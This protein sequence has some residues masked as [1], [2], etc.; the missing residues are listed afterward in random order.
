M[1]VK[2]ERGTE[3]LLERIR[4]LMQVGA[5]ESNETVITSERHKSLIDRALGARGRRKK[6]TGKIC[7]WIVFPM[8]FGNAAGF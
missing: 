4:E 5:V 1:S 6:A 3:R 7:R 8:T 2:E